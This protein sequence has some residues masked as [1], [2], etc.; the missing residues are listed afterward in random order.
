MEFVP[1]ESRFTGITEVQKGIKLSPSTKAVR[2]EIVKSLQA[3]VSLALELQ[4]ENVPPD[5][6]AVALL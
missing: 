1:P 5:R 3:N 4:G 2:A 6:V